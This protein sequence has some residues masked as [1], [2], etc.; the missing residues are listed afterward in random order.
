MGNGTTVFVA[1]ASAVAIHIAVKVLLSPLRDIPGPWLAKVTDL[2]RLIESWR[3]RPDISHNKLH[4]KYGPA[5][6][7][8][9]NCVSISDPAL[10][11]TIFSTWKKDNMYTKS[12][13][14]GVA[15]FPLDGKYFPT[16]FSVRDEQLHSTMTRKANKL[17]AIPALIQFE[18]LT[19]AAIEV[20]LSR[21][22][23][24][25]VSPGRSCPIHEWLHFLAWDMIAEM[26]FSRK[27]GFL[28]TGKDVDDIIKIGQQSAD[29]LAVIGQMHWLDKFLSKNPFITIGPPSSADTANFAAGLLA[30]RRSGTDRHD[31]GRP[32]FLDEFIKLQD[33]DSSVTDGEVVAW[34]L[35]NVIAGSDTTAIEMQSIVYFLSKNRQA[36]EKLQTE[37][38]SANLGLS[39]QWKDVSKLPYLD[40]VVN[41]ALRCHPV[42]GILWERVVPEKGLTLPDGRFIPGGTIV[43]M[44]PRVVHRDRQAFGEDVDTFRPERWL[45]DVEVGEPVEVYEA[46]MRKMR[47][48]SM[49]FGWGKR[50][51]SGK[52]VAIIEMR[53]VAAAMYSNFNIELVNPKK[54][55]DRTDR[56]FFLHKDL[57]MVI[58]ERKARRQDSAIPGN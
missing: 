4:E 21:L 50:S 49:P 12:D 53:K 36:K 42:V 24:E 38:D 58:T 29:Y 19:D 43:G 51:C 10:I 56:F 37:L 23:E 25:F 33:A 16:T 40:A 47:D 45:R 39:P 28:D 34:M 20:F 1:I 22:R 35:S 41:E 55:F 7:I 14:Y 8:G 48:A 17:Y 57:D 18:P 31:I 27:F 6:R 32:D 26:T 3:G 46:R 2:W 9:P 44:N 54:V 52:N 30:A 13:F 15:D 11:K 5:V